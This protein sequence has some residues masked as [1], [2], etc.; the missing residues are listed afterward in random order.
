MAVLIGID[1]AGYG[2]VLG[3]LT[4]SST[5]F[6]VPEDKLRS[7]MWKVLSSSVSKQKRSLKGK[8]LITDSKKAYNRKSGLGHLE[9]TTLATLKSMGISAKNFKE[10]V[11][12]LAPEALARLNHYPWYQK[13]EDV[14]IDF[15][16]A[17]YSIAAGAFK[18]DREKNGISIVALRSEVL[19]VGYY[20]EM[21]DKVQNKASVLF[22]AVC[23]HIDWAFKHFGNDNLQI[24]VDRQGGRSHYLPVLAKMFPQSQGR[25]IREDETDCSY[26]LIDGDRKMRIHFVVKADDKSLPV[27]LASII[28][29]YIRE[30]MME[31]LNSYFAGFDATIAPTAGYWTD[32]NRF[33][34]DTDKII[35]CQKINKK[36]LVRLR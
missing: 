25:I 2:P 33:I 13:L 15:E 26:E 24:V 8:I 32:G 34:K 10:L 3:P 20:N 30:M 27:S 12:V 7:D 11:N 17:E 23:R 5:A 4:V 1:E 21:V 22:T 36:M 9:R 19:D 29:K 35:E 31:R 16:N 6:M 14:E 18:T 28:S